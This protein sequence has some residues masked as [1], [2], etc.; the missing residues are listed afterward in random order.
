MEVL[1]RGRGPSAQEQGLPIDARARRTQDRKPAAA[2][3]HAAAGL[4]G[5][6][7]L[8]TV[9]DA[10]SL[11]FAVPQNNLTELWSL[12]H[13]VLPQIFTDLEV[14]TALHRTA[15][16]LS[17]C[18]HA[19]ACVCTV[20]TART[21]RTAHTAHKRACVHARTHPYTQ[22]FK[23]WFDF[24]ENIEMAETS[25]IIEAH[26]RARERAGQG[27]AGAGAEVPG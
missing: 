10:F 23:S 9:L 13:F 5:C 20:R 19:R 24:D 2:H 14:C 26:T 17:R 6:A 3:W 8:P 25:K 16:R 11:P 18:M 21:A 22:S 4:W 12:L 15:P 7:D 1:D 27:S